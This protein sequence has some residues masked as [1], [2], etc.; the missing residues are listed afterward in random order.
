MAMPLKL[1]INFYK[2]KYDARFEILTLEREFD[3]MKVWNCWSKKLRVEFAWI[4]R[5]FDVFF[6]WF[7]LLLLFDRPAVNYFNDLYSRVMT[8]GQ[9]TSPFILQ[10]PIISTTKLLFYHNGPNPFSVVGLSRLIF[11]RTKI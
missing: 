5:A 8:H 1:K 10:R 4:G 7:F 2:I 3:K 6:L 11:L 9:V